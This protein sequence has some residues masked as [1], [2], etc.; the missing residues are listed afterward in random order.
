[1]NARFLLTLLFIHSVARGDVFRIA[2]VKTQKDSQTERMTYGKDEVIFVNKASV[3]TIDDIESA[4]PSSHQEHAISVKLKPE[5]AK[6]LRITTERLQPGVDRL[7]I[8]VDGQVKSAPVIQ[9][10]LGGAFEVSGFDELDARGLENLARRMSGRSILKDDEEVTPPA[11]PPK[12]ETVPYTEEE[13]RQLKKR[14]EEMGIFY[15]DAMPSEKELGTRLRKGMSHA[16]VLT[17]FGRPTSGSKAPTEPDFRLSYDVAPERL[18]ENAKRDAIPNGFAIDF[19]NGKVVGWSRGFTNSQREEKPLHHSPRALKA[20]YPKIDFSDENMDLVGFFEGIKIENP[21][22]KITVADLGDLLSLVS[23]FSNAPDIQKGD[24]S[25]A[26]D[27]MRALAHH[28]PEVEEL[29]RKARQGRVPIAPLTQSLS[30][31]FT[32]EKLWPTPPDKILPSE[33]T[34]P[35]EGSK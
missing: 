8:I 10:A 26:C 3:L 7:A 24:V 33:P 5:G 29:R 4:T 27:V 6:K 16:E 30:P 18:P 21:R 25:S 31:Y 22:Q 9:Q 15:L 13:Y 28:F 17:E 12:T 19:T 1:M 34:S 32:G 11:K 35:A 2:E 14:R 23:L 20:I